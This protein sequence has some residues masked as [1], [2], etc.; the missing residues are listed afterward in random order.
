[1]Q[2]VN[3]VKG[4]L[5]MLKSPGTYIVKTRKMYILFFNLNFQL[6]NCDHISSKT[7]NILLKET[8]ESTNC[9]IIIESHLQ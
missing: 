2:I 1:M 3:Q 5:Q 4:G 9:H 8:P 6:Q 7:P